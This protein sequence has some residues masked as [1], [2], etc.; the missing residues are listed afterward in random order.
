MMGRRRDPKAIQDIKGNPGRRPLGDAPG[1][2]ADAP[3]A[4]AADMPG[5][6]AAA[7]LLPPDPGAGNVPLWLQAEDQAEAR[8]VWEDLAP[9]IVATNLMRTTDRQAFGRYCRYIVEWR[10]ADRKLADGEHDVCYETDSAHGKMM[11]VNPW[12]L[13]RDRLERNLLG[14]EDRFGLSPAARQTVISRQAAIANLPLFG[15]AA[16]AA[17]NADGAPASPADEP[18]RGPV[19]I[20]S[21]PPSNA[22]N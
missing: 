2:G 9:Q 1:S 17:S 7:E 21:A 11:R 13:V 15:A 4:A 14:L 20:L 18:T 6:A 5:Q 3:G 8:A 16:A 12:F 22:V 19:G 10:A